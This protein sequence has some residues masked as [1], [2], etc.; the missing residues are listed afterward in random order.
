MVSN[1]I[2]ERGGGGGSDG[3][4]AHV[5][6]HR[7]EGTNDEAAPL[8]STY[9]LKAK[10]NRRQSRTTKQTNDWFMY[11]RT[12]FGTIPLGLTV[13]AQFTRVILTV[14]PMHE[15]KIFV[16]FRPRYFCVHS[17]TLSRQHI[18]FPR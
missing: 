8:E 17:P 15:E 13:T 9:T 7:Q 16:Q 11:Y 3:S 4:D 6:G 5:F 18:Q 2:L 12:R 14:K 10:S 1:G